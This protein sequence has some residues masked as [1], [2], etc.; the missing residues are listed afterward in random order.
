MSAFYQSSSVILNKQNYA[1]YIVSLRVTVT[2]VHFQ[3]KKDEISAAFHPLR[4]SLSATAPVTI[5]DII[6]ARSG[7]KKNYFQFYSIIV[8]MIMLL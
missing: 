5:P 4:K 1:H 3:T 6:A 8:T 2:V 7:K